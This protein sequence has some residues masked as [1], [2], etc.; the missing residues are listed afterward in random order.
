M[1]VKT[2]ETLLDFTQAVSTEFEVE[3]LIATGTDAL[4]GIR[5]AHGD[6]LLLVFPFD[7]QVLASVANETNGMRGDLRE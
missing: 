2:K 7:E 3:E 1:S 4:R 5:R 6:L